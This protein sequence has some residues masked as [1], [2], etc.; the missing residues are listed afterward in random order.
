MREALARI[1]LARGDPVQ[2]TTEADELR[3]LAERTGSARHRALADLLTGSAAM[4]AGDAERGRGLLHAA[5][6][7][8]EE[9]GLER[10]AA[11]AL[12]E[13]ALAAA[14]AGDTWRAARLAGAAGA[15]RD[16][17]A[18]VPAKPSTERLTTIGDSEPAAWDEGAALTLADAVA[19]ARRS[20]GP[21]DRPDAG[22][23]SLTPTEQE[24]AQLAATGLSNPQIAT[25]LFMARGTVKM[26]LSNVYLKLGIANRTELARASATRAPGNSGQVAVVSPSGPS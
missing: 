17:L 8:H 25:R 2:A 3:A 13:L 20:R 23:S 22:W 5:L 9:L 16:R 21:R 4:R 6:T 18:T 12:D 7:V 15:A 1:A 19:Y 11:D 14:D 10:G 24:V 26:H